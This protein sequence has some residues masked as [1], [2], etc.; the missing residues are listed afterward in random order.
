MLN[1]LTKKEWVE[2]YDIYRKETKGSKLPKDYIKHRLTLELTSPADV[3]LKYASSLLEE[4]EGN[5]SL[6]F[7]IVIMLRFKKYRITEESFYSKAKVPKGKLTKDR[8][9]STWLKIIYDYYRESYAC[10]YAFN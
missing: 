8:V 7:L 2:V 10:L 1:S 9:L 4:G 6:Y 5:P 3:Y